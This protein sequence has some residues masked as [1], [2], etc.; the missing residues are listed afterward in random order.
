MLDFVRAIV[1]AG[2]AALKIDKQILISK[3]YT[4]NF[5]NRRAQS[6][7]VYGWVVETGIGF[8][9]SICDPI[10]YVD[11]LAKVDQAQDRRFKR[12]AEK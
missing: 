12:K 6:P 2:S 10:G 4:E 5:S 1:A 11:G 8:R 9:L 3:F 7:R